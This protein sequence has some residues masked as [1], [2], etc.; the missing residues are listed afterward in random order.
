MKTHKLYWEDSYLTSFSA[1]VVR[2]VKEDN[3]KPRWCRPKSSAVWKSY[4]NYEN[5]KNEKVLVFTEGA[6]DALKL[7]QFGYPA[8]AAKNFSPYQIDR[9]INS[10]VRY[11]ITMYDNDEA[12]RTAVN[13]YG[14]PIHFTAKANYVFSDCGIK[15]IDAKLPDY[16][17][18]PA[19]VNYDSDIVR[20]N[21]ILREIFV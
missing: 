4:F 20:C 8:I 13:K 19:A 10:N 3:L 7:I 5:V 16:A 17:K 1:K 21:P 14:Y 11:I 18:D 2:Y 12:G 15:V 9:I 6:T